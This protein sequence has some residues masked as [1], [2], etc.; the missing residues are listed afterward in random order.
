MGHNLG[1]RHDFSECLSDI[2]N[3]KYV[4]RKYHG[5]ECRGLMDYV[6]DGIGWSQCSMMDFS[7][8]ITWNSYS[9]GGTW[10]PCLEG[11]VSSNFNCKS[12][13]FYKV[14][15]KSVA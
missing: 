11:T 13:P 1:M 8:Y 2:E 3:K 7:R 12:C 14:V 5:K 6:D 4:Y 15:Y 9:S 10:K